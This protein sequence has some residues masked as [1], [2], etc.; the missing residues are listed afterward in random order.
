M[1]L[2]RDYDFQQS[3]H[4]PRG[5]KSHE[6]GHVLPHTRRTGSNVRL[7]AGREVVS[8]VVPRACSS[9]GPRVPPGTKEGR[10]LPR[11]SGARKI[12]S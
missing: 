1:T 9:V 5:T 8:M 3:G 12:A 4:A 10:Q 7:W 6:H 11:G 2:G